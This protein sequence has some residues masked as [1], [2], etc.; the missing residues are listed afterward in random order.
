MDRIA[1]PIHGTWHTIASSV[2]DAFHGGGALQR[3]V[4]WII[5]G[6]IALSITI[7]CVEAWLGAYDPL[8]QWLAPIDI[9]LLWVFGLE[10]ILRITSYRPPSL[11]FYRNSIIGEA[12]S[13]IGGRIRF[14]FRPLMLIDI[15]TVL[16]LVPAL[17]GLR[18]LRLLR[19]LRAVRLFR[20]SSPLSG[21]ARAFTDNAIL[22]LFAFSLVGG[23]TMIG[24][25]SLFFIEHTVN[26]NITNLAD[27]LWWGL[28]T[29]TTVGFGDIAPVTGLGRI[30]G[31]CLMVVG[32][33]TLGLFAGIVAQTLPRA[34]LGIRKEQIRMSG[35]V[36]HL[37]ICGYE[38]GA[39]LFLQTLATEMDLNNEIV[40][41]CGQTDRPKELPPDFIWVDANP[42]KETELDKLRL[43]YAAAVVLVGSRTLSAHQADAD[44]ILVAFTIRAHLEKKGLQ[45]KRKRP[46]YIVA[47]VLDSENADHLTAAGVDEVIE[48]TRLGFSLL[49][50]AITQHGTATLMGQFGTAGAHSLY[51]G[52]PPAEIM[53]AGVLFGDVCRQIRETTGALV[54]GLRE[55]GKD[56]D[57]INPPLDQIVAADAQLVYLAEAPV[58]P[59]V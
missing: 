48:T 57:D 42:A 15:I 20:Y 40:V 27:S 36:N 32:M 28:V 51:V 21:L 12:R 47:E 3:R 13:H 8:V 14:C 49:T 35:H 46:L 1:S 33:L 45:A 52:A 25:L 19:M 54:I 43:A 56:E 41:V 7:L 18:A 58:L 55:P 10:V 6:L 38:S 29:L 17:R 44:T 31:G 2:H 11:D 37:V 30:V 34:I 23:A 53:T 5:Y 24:G 16:A 22:Y 50:H 39:E 9:F 26:P 4:E 59:Q